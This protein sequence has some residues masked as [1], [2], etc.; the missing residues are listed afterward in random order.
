MFRNYFIAAIRNL[1][2][3]KIFSFINILGLAIGISASL[4]IFLIIQY[5]FSFDHFEKNK[6]RIYR[7]VSVFN[8]SGEEY[9]NSGVPSPLGKTMN[10]EISGLDLS[11]HF[12]MWT[13]NETLRVQ[14]PANKE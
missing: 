11:A 4:V 13:E 10:S 8:F 3:N 14:D 9:K 5:D 6:D 2:S 1:R 12:R 7:V